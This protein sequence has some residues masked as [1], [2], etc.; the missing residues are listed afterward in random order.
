MV[1]ENKVKHMT[2]LAVFEKKEGKEI[3]KTSKYFKSDY[4]TVNVLKTAITTTIAYILIVGLYCFLNMQ[5]ILAELN[6]MDLVAVAT[7]LIVY[8]VILLIVYLAIAIV[9]YSA[10]YDRARKKV[11][12]YVSGLNKLDKIN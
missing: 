4:V 9:V 1:N 7:D 10:K 12:K 5:E 8:Y 6:S 2:R 3:Q 11:K